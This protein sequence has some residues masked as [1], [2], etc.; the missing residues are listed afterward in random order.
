MSNKKGF[1]IPIALII[2][3]SLSIIV[4]SILVIST[5]NVKKVDTRADR[6]K[7]RN[8]AEAGLH[9]ALWY[10][11]NDPIAGGTGVKWRTQDHIEAF[12]GGNYSITIVDDTADEDLFIITSTGNYQSTIKVLE[13][14][15]GV[16]FGGSFVDYAMHSDQAIGINP[17]ALVF[18]NIYADGDVTVEA[19]AVVSRGSIKVTKGYMVTGEGNYVIGPTAEDNPTIIDYAYF[20]AI[21]D[22][23]E[24]SGP[25]IIQGDQS[26]G[27]F[28]LNGLTLYVNGS[29]TLEGEVKGPGRIAASEQIYVENLAEIDKKI[30]LIAGDKLM[31][32]QYSE[33]GRNDLLYAGNQIVFSN[34][35]FNKHKIIALTPK[36]LTIGQNV[37]IQGIFFGDNIQVGDYTKL[38]GSLISGTLDNTLDI[39]QGVE[40]IYRNFYGKIPPGFDFR[41]K[42]YKW[43]KK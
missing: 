14:Q 31:I 15:A 26:Y 6:L 8:I 18:G 33:L 1:I 19:G 36:K 17:H 41:I 16:T 34:G 28:D 23:I 21:F 25:D 35:L 32:K 5:T 10:L 24:A 29:V 37:D 3:V 39:G 22:L 30:E 27:T 12:G 2:I 20:I 9:K 42:I 40:L 13:V 11:S 38:H 43:L 4:G 7:A